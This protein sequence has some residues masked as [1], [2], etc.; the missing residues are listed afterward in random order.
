MALSGFTEE[1]DFFF[2]NVNKDMKARRADD[3]SHGATVEKMDFAFVMCD[4]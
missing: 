1:G 4:Y 2:S 3:N